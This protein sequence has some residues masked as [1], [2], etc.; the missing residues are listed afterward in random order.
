M[1]NYVQSC[2]QYFIPRACGLT[3]SDDDKPSL[4]VEDPKSYRGVAVV[5][6]AGKLTGYFSVGF[7]LLSKPVRLISPHA[8]LPEK[9]S[10]AA[11]IRQKVLIWR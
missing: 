4:M 7:F 1:I 2:S 10:H 3:P 11:F 8:V 5:D 6:D 9:Y